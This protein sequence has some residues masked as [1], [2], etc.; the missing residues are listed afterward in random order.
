MFLN[1]VY[2]SGPFAP[3]FKTVLDFIRDKNKAILLVKT[4]GKGYFISS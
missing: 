2:T 3:K 4:K 1:F